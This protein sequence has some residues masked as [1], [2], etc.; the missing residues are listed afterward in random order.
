MADGERQNDDDAHVGGDNPR[1]NFSRVPMPILSD[2]Q[3]VEYWFIR[4]ESWFRLQNITDETIRYEAVVAPLT[5]Q[6]FDQVV[7]LITSPSETEQYT[8]LKAA[9]IEKFADS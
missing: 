6:L 4:L 2:T 1:P 7:D 8:K 3:S 5:P 9:L